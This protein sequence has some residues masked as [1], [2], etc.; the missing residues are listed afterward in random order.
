MFAPKTRVVGVRITEKDYLRLIK[1]A[2]AKKEV[3]EY[4]RKLIEKKGGK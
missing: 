4:I 1:K 3:P 2:G